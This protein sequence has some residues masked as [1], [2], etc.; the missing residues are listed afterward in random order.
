MTINPAL[1][2]S[3]KDD[4]ETPDDLFRTL[5]A[6]YKFTTDAAASHHNHKLPVYFTKEQ[7]GLKQNWAGQRVWI[8]PPYGLRM[9][10]W[11]RKAEN[12]L[13]LGCELVVFL[14]PART[15]VKWFHR[16]VYKKPNVEIQFLPGRLKFKGA[17]NAAPFPSMLV[18]M[19][20]WTP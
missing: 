8:N 17:K 11:F 7:N 15:D 6:E 5:N 19:K 1:F 9:G 2:S 14:V 12:E 18:I 20:P 13:A 3:A 16:Y 4:W 10:D